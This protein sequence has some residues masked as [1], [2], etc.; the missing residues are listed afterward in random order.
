MRRSEIGR[1]KKQGQQSDLEDGKAIF[2]EGWK[3]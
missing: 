2:Q 1:R 3:D